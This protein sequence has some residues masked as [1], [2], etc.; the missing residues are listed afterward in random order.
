MAAHVE[1]EPEAPE[2]E[3]ADADYDS[4]PF[5]RH[6]NSIPC[7]GRCARCGHGCEQHGISGEDTAC[8][9]RDC[10]CPAWQEEPS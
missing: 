1:F 2:P 9:A 10:E 4:G 5:C 6:W 3:G 7:G 8:D